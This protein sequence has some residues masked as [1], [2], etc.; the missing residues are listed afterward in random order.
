MASRLIRPAGY[1]GT[2]VLSTMAW[3]V[4]AARYLLLPGISPGLLLAKVGLCCVSRLS[5]RSG[6]QPAVSR[7]AQHRTVLGDIRIAASIV[8]LFKLVLRNSCVVFPRCKES[9][10]EYYPTI[11][12]QA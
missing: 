11:W 12:A 8:T 3:D 6:V 9:R 2:W 7:A 5:S 10:Q 1:L 4:P